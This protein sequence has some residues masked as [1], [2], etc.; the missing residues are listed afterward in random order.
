MCLL[1]LLEL[2]LLLMQ[3]LLDLLLCLLAHLVLLHVLLA[4]LLGLVVTAECIR[5][6]K[7]LLALDTY[8]RLG[9]CMHSNMALEIVLA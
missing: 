5:A 8:V 1:R 7:G 4:D 9:S 6:G 3:L 2:E